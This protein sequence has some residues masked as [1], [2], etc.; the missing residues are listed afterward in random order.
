MY[1]DKTLVCKDCGAEFVFTAGEQEFYFAQNAENLPR[2]LLSLRRTGPYT[3][4]SALLPAA[5]K[6]RSKKTVSEMR[7]FFVIY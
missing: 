5:G 6:E 2:F 4:A 7:Q 1:E 3:A